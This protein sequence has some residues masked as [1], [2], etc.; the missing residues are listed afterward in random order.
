MINLSLLIGILIGIAFTILYKRLNDTNNHLPKNTSQKPIEN[1]IAYKTNISPNNHNNSTKLTQPTS[2]LK[3][4]APTITKPASSCPYTFKLFIYPFEHLLPSFQLAEQARRNQTYH[5]C[6]KCIYEQF[7]LE[8]IVYDYFSQ[9]CGRTMN[10]D[11]ADFF[12]IPMIR[13]V[14]QCIN[15]CIAYCTE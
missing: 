6:H 9:F 15:E 11:E 7:A 3:A 1:S 12:Y 14:L 4:S 2:T 10:P 5:I 13:Y 8:Y